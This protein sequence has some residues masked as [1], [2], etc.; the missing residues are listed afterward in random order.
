MQNANKKTIKMNGWVKLL[1][2]RHR[3]KN[4]LNKTKKNKKGNIFDDGLVF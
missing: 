4:S 3:G 2:D 1:N